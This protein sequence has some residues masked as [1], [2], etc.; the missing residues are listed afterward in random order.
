MTFHRRSPEAYYIYYKYIN[1]TYDTAVITH[2]WC[3]YHTLC[4]ACDGHVCLCVCLCVCMCV[5]ICVCVRCTLYVCAW[6]CA[7]V[8]L[9]M[10]ARI[11]L[12]S[13]VSRIYFTR[14]QSSASSSLHVHHPAYNSTCDVHN[15]AYRNTMLQCYTITLYLI[16]LLYFNIL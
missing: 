1:N 13:L 11:S 16:T 3:T 6:L 8:S 4:E 12:T 2:V 14:N 10:H 5:Y 9:I 15:E 7:Q